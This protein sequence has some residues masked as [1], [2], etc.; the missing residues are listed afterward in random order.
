M[1][2]PFFIGHWWVVWPNCQ[3]N[4]AENEEE[5][6]PPQ[7]RPQGQQWGVASWTQQQQVKDAWHAVP[8][9]HL[10]CTHM[11][12]L[13]IEDYP[14]DNNGLT[15]LLFLDL[16]KA[17]CQEIYCI[18]TDYSGPWHF[19]FKK[20]PLLSSKARWVYPFSKHTGIVPIKKF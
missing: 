1:N 18:H 2:G 3:G 10:D 19:T 5:G 8:G 6:H 16:K 14:Q 12:M 9:N 20:S 17:S 13:W 11:L 15:H 7:K 4:E